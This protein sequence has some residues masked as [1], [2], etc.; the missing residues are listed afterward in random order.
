MEIV[1]NAMRSI[2]FIF[3]NVIYGLIPIVYKLFIPK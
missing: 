3:D 1:D 2:G